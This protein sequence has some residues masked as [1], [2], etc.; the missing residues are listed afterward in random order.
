M[1][2]D[3]NS[4]V[5]NKQITLPQLLNNNVAASDVTATSNASAAVQQTTILTASGTMTITSTT[6]PTAPQPPAFVE[7]A[8]NKISIVPIPIASPKLAP[9]QTPIVATSIASTALAINP[10]ENEETPN[11]SPTIEAKTIEDNV[12][13]VPMEGITTTPIA[14]KERKRRIVVDDDDESPTFNPLS[15]SSKKMKGR[16][17]RGRGALMR[18]NQRKMLL[19]S[20]EKTM[21]STSPLTSATTT[22]IMTTSAAIVALSMTSTTTVNDADSNLFTSPEGIVS[23][24]RVNFKKI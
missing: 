15:R 6:A 23:R 11:S 2:S 22:T 19:Q 20:P 13:A 16:G 12:V 17:R 24:T 10:A 9:T 7:P 14:S 3:H 1:M 18:P 4:R 21:D 5:T 8:E